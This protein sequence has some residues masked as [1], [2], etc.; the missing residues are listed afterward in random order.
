[1]DEIRTSFLRKELARLRREI[2]EDKEDDKLLKS[3]QKFGFQVNPET[4]KLIHIEEPKRRV[5][6]KI[7]I[8]KAKALKRPLT[9][10]NE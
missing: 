3:Q 7:R 2:A 5:V 1:M 6:K 4:G 10:G 9:L 8:N